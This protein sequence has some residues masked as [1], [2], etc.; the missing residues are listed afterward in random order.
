MD[1]SRRY[2]H[3]RFMDDSRRYDQDRLMDDLAVR[4][5]AS[6]AGHMPEML[7]NI[8]LGG[9]DPK[10][11]D[12][13]EYATHA[14]SNSLLDKNHDSA[15][16]RLCEACSQITLPLPGRPYFHS[17]DIEALAESGKR[18][19]LCRLM[20][21]KICEELLVSNFVGDT[22]HSSQLANVDIV[23]ECR[24]LAT[25][26]G[27]ILPEKLPLFMFYDTSESSGYRRIMI[28]STAL[29]SGPDSERYGNTFESRGWTLGRLAYHKD[30]GEEAE[31]LRP[32]GDETM[33]LRRLRDWL[34]ASEETFALWSDRLTDT[35][36]PT[37]ILDLGVED[38][39]IQYP[40]TTD[41]RLIHGGGSTGRYATLSY[42]WG[43]FEECRTLRANI[44][45]R[46]K[47]IQFLEM[48]RSFQDAVCVTR[49]LGIRYLWIDAL[50]IIQD[51]AED[52]AREAGNMAD[53]YWNGACRLAVTSCRRPTESFFPPQD[54]VASVQVPDYELR[55]DDSGSEQ[56]NAA[57]RSLTS[58]TSHNTDPFGG[59]DDHGRPVVT[60][61]DALLDL[62][63]SKATAARA[64]R[65][66]RHEHAGGS[67]EI[68]SPKAFVTLPKTYARDVDGG[69]LNTR[70]WVLQERLLA[71]RT[72]HFTHDHIYCEDTDDICGEDWV[73]RQLTFRS[74]IRKESRQ[75][76]SI[77]FPSDSVKAADNNRLFQTPQGQR[78]FHQRGSFAHGNYR[79]M[80]SSENIWYNIVELYTGCKFKEI[81]DKAI[82]IAGL[83]KQKQLSERGERSVSL[84]CF[85]RNHQLR[86]M[87]IVIK[88]RWA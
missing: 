66:N 13:S 84:I 17:R 18:C 77:A 29:V 21:F 4:F 83:V 48:P 20:R 82:A 11:L 71:P 80:T 6:I 64:L 43:G 51:D 37:R 15:A 8:G 81:S 46:C 22:R 56:T 53:V 60:T 42:C 86:P 72:I 88:F 26:A 63:F 73:R 30:D 14:I 2:G 49:G 28:G 44:D 9:I 32:R 35:V 16:G 79:H 55:N 50:C 61:F 7:Q 67:T 34:E 27:D 54:I 38:S 41:L 23:G 5:S 45:D 52:W 75:S 74:C 24:Q 40:S 10:T 70:G 3:D 47:K 57:S 68:R 87:I 76:R 12:F 36:L 25:R 33:T 69:Y 58:P 78:L 62:E 59:T 39:S 19:D 85:A 65:V 1:N 31:P